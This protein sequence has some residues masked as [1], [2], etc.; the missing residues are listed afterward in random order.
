MRYNIIKAISITEPAM[1]EI[2]PISHIP[3]IPTDFPFQ[4]KRLIFQFRSL[5][6]LQLI[7]HWD[8]HLNI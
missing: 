8:K 7:N 2:A 6:Q 1:G 3:V 4:Y 5:M